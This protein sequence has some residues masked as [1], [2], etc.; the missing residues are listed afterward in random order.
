MESLRTIPL[1]KSYDSD[2]DDLLRDFYIPSLSVSIM[3]RRIAGF[4]SS[5]SFALAAS[6]LAKFLHSQGRMQL[7][8]NV[9]LRED[10]FKAMQEGMT[11]PEEIVGKMMLDS[12]QSF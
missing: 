2:E 4:F 8:L 9:A 12:L 10:D 6:G 11:H 3:Y 5:T 7:I 1:K